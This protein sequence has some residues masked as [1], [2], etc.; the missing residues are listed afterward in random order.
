MTGKHQAL[1]ITEHVYWVG[2]IDWKLRDF[3]GYTTG[4][5]STYNAF[6]IVG[7]KVVLIDAVKAPF[8][9]EMMDRIASVLSPE[10][11][12][13]IVSNHTEMDH[14]GCLP[15]V[16]QAV[17]PEAIIASP[18]GARDLAEHFAFDRPVRIVQDGEQVDLGDGATLTFYHSPM[19]HWPDSMVT[20]YDRD[21]VVFSQD[22]F[23]M[24]LASDERVWDQLDWDALEFEAAKYY[25]N[26]LM[27]FS[28]LVGRFVEKFVALGL[29]IQ[30]VAPDHGPVWTG[31]GI[32]RILDLYRQWSSGR[33]GRKVVI[34][35]DTMWESTDA[36]ARAI[37]DG[38]VAAGAPAR[39]IRLSESNR[40]DVATE[41]LD[42]GALIVGSPTLNGMIFPTLAD[43]LSYLAGLKPQGM[44]GAAFGSY[45]WSGQATAQI[46]QALEKMKVEVVHP[47]L[48][49]KY[50]PTEADLAACRALGAEVVSRLPVQD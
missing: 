21:G 4:R 26:I 1:Q 19:L 50:V 28:P 48:Q 45:G 8:Q 12:D 17:N 44:I 18:N 6:L 46:K 11:I 36:M 5:G 35:Y 42:A 25:A 37:E 40:S 15:Q 32:G 3:H 22:A 30:M 31:E 2:A 41:T 49:V 23:G 16:I 14:T 27:P 43:V 7:E 38:V 20:W 9:Q 13:I 33:R 34:V 47:G 24:H 39:R 10:K 29:P